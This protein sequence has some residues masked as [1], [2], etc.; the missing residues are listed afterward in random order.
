M[1]KI[2]I[3]IT[4][5]CAVV[6]VFMVTVRVY[7][8]I[9]VPLDSDPIANRQMR[10]ESMLL[11]CGSAAVQWISEHGRAPTT[12]EGL[13][14]LPLQNFPLLDGWKQQIVYRARGV[15]APLEFHIYSIGPN[16]VDEGGGG[17]DISFEKSQL[18][19]LK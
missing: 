13:A 18:S 11:L 17:D 3:K 14:V 2:K 8:A 5:V 15:T 4:I 16:G 10:T 7:Y 9:T 12:S 1:P 19:N 6:I